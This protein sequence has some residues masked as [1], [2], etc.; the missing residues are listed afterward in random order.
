MYAPFEYR[1]YLVAHI[2][3]RYVAKSL[4]GEPCELGSQDLQKVVQ[5]IDSLWSS[6][7][8]GLPL[9]FLVEDFIDLDTP[10]GCEALQPTPA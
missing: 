5:A 1:S 9:K 10:E 6:L 4:D 3:G 8:D 2:E 7:S